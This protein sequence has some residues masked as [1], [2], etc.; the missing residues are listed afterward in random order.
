MINWLNTNG[1]KEWFDAI[2]KLGW[3]DIRE[4]ADND[5]A[6]NVAEWVHLFGVERMQDRFKTSMIYDNV[7]KY[8]I[9]KRLRECEAVK[10]SDCSQ[11]EK[12]LKSINNIS[13]KY[14]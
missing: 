5:P 4:A 1:Q 14:A 2:A 9:D 3:F 7:D 10:P 12:D 11:Q 13:K 8:R 6:F